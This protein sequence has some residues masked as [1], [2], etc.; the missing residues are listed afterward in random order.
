[1]MMLKQPRQEIRILAK[2]ISHNSKS[3]SDCCF[4]TTLFDRLGPS[5]LFDR[6]GPSDSGPIQESSAIELSS[7]IFLS[8]KP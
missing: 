5:N 6:L 4:L 7:L 8:V 2:S 3:T 1:M